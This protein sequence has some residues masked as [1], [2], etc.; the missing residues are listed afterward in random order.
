MWGI[1]WQ[2]REVRSAALVRGGKRFRKLAVERLEVRRLLSA[3]YY[4]NVAGLGGTPSDNN[5]GAIDQPLATL[6]AALDRV[7]PGDTVIIRGGTYDLANGNGPNTFDKSGLPGDPLTIEAYPGEQPISTWACRC[8]GRW[9]RPDCGTATCRRG[10]GVAIA[11]RRAPSRCQDRRMDGDQHL[12]QRREWRA[13]AGIH[14]SA[15][16]FLSRRPARL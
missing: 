1:P 6:Q 13:A 8:S 7:G 14:G 3:T 16:G 2:W 10:A 4:V 12:R 11:V 5:T 15:G 9:F